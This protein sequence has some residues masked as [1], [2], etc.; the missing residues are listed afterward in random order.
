MIPKQPDDYVAD[1]EL[2]AVWYAAN[3]Y[4]AASLRAGVEYVGV[5]FRRPD[6][7]YVVTAHRGNSLFDCE[8]PPDRVP[9]CEP[10]ALW[11]THIPLSRIDDSGELDGVAQAAEAVR[12]LFGGGMNDFSSAD[13][14]VADELTKRAQYPF[15]VYLITLM[16]IKRYTPGKPDV[17]WSK[18]PPARLAAQMRKQ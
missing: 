17:Q 4:Y 10:V 1:T 18:D 2:G 14:G 15:S 5:V 7:K 13:R 16:L 12:T 9:G 6:G 8:V 11:H 3:Q